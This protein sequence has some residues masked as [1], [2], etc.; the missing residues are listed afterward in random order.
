MGQVGFTSI[1]YSDK[2]HVYDAYKT[3]SEENTIILL[4][5]PSKQHAES[6]KAANIFH[7]VLKRKFHSKHL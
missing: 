5:Q 6:N 4:N 1:F 2:K 3:K 7:V